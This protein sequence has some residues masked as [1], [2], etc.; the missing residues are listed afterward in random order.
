VG[1]VG[2]SVG[3]TDRGRLSGL[4]SQRALYDGGGVQQPTRPGQAGGFEHFGL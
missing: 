2:G 1:A 3:G 4:P